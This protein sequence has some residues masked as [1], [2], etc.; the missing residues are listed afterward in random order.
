MVDRR[1]LEYH[2]VQHSILS[3]EVALQSLTLVVPL[4][5][6]KHQSPVRFIMVVSDQELAGA[7]L[8]THILKSC[9]PPHR[10][11][12]LLGQMAPTGFRLALAA[13]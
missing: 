12:S 3:L 8:L 2:W 5:G 11:V 6:E 4:I 10:H 9:D 7:R 13:K 1:C